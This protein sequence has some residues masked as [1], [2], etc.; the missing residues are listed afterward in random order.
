MTIENVLEPEYLVIEPSGVGALSNVI[1]NLRKIEYGRITVL[2][3]LTIVDAEHFVQDRAAFTDIYEDQIKASATVAISKPEHPDAELMEAVRAQ[4]KELNP[5]A[6][7]LAHHYTQMPQAWWESLLNTRCDGRRL[8]EIDESA[9]DLET[10]SIPE[11][12]A[13]SPAALLWI[14]EQAVHGRFGD[15]VRAKGILPAGMDW[16][17]FDIVNGKISITGLG[18]VPA[19]AKAECVWIGRAIDRLPLQNFLARAL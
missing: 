18:G 17:S 5:D 6:S 4:V 19:G 16:V 2:Q 1:R 8:D 7:V 11:C 3:P 14:L 9:L 13:D 10:F 12:R 15:I